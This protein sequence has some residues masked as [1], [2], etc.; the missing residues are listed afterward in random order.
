MEGIF[1]DLEDKL[2][3]VVTEKNRK[4]IKYTCSPCKPES[5]DVP[6]VQ[7]CD[8]KA[9]TCIWKPMNGK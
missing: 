1:I 3:A 6:C 7:A 8:Q 5:E 9:I 4:K 2:V